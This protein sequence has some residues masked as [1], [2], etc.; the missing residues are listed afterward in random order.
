MIVHRRASRIVHL[1]KNLV[2]L[3][4]YRIGLKKP[5][6]HVRIHDNPDNTTLDPSPDDF[7][8]SHA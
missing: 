7:N 6:L 2:G 8:R 1:E 5:I 3:I 4:T